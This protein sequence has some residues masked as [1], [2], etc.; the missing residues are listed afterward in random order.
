MDNTELHYLTYDPDAILS[1]MV[2]AYISAGGDGIYPGDEKEILLQGVL[3]MFVQSFAGVDNALRMATLRYATGDYLDLIGENRDCERIAAVA[4][5]ATVSITFL[6]SGIQTT[7]PAG[8]AMTADGRLMWSL[9]EDITASGSAETITAAITCAEAGTQGNNL[10]A[11]TEM[12]MAIATSVV[13]SIIVTS[14]GTGGENREE[15]DVYRER[16]RLHGLANNT[17]GPAAQYEAI[18]MET[19]GEIIDANAVNTGAGQVTVYLLLEEGSTAADVISEVTAAL[20]AE[21]VRPLT[22]IVTVAE[23]TALNYTLDVTVTV[24]SSTAT[25]DLDSAVEEYQ[26][27]QDRKIGRAFNPDRLKALLYQAGATLVTFENTS[28]FNG[29]AVEYTEI[30]VDEHCSGT[31]NLVVSGT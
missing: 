27:W 14:G 5:T 7:F 8:T 15:D 6:N 1:D 16:I 20:S 11:G 12:Q 9:D 19:S 26:E 4:A 31:V 21:S 25:A 13:G 2:A 10:T 17:A 24:E 29:G 23:A 18:A 3:Q 22:D 28:S 30:D